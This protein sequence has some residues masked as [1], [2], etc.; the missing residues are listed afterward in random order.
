MA[1]PTQAR[2]AIGTTIEIEDAPGSGTFV[3]IAEPVDIG[4][5]GEV[6]SFVDATNLDSPDATREYI[7]GLLDPP[8][9]TLIF[10]DVPSDA[11]QTQLKTDAD[12]R[13]T[14][15][16]RITI[17]PTT[18]ASETQAL[19]NIVLAGKMIESPVVDAPLQ[20]SVAGKQTGKATFQIP[21]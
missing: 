13:S 18:P 9:K 17:P 11:G 16:F 20:L 2:L 6:G 7:A 1:A 4:G 3:N 5:I 12:A 21:A 8:D 14:I 15:L 10:R 19:I